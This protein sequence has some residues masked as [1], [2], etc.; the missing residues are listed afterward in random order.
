MANFQ[1]RLRQVMEETGVK[2]ADLA[3]ATG[4]SKPA[5]SKYLSDSKKEP[6][7]MKVLMIANFFNVTSEWLYGA[8]DTRK[9]FYEPSIVEVYEKLS[10]EG[11]KQAYDF[12]LFLLE[13]ELG[14]KE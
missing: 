14:V 6:S 4:I 2:A 9:P 11:K 8:T 5:I 10:S 1:E 3:R 12:T 13:K 7:A